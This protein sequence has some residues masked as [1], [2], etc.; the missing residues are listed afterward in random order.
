MIID[1]PEAGIGV[2]LRT[3]GY[4][5]VSLVLWT[6]GIIAVGL[7]SNVYGYINGVGF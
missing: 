4:N 6:V 7:V 2:R 5:C 1:S 3:G